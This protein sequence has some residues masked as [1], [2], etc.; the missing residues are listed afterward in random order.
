[1]KR[2]LNTIILLDSDSELTGLSIQCD[3][4]EDAIKVMADGCIVTNN[5][6]KDT[7][8]SRLPHRDAIQ[9]IPR[10][11]HQ[12]NSQFFG[13]T[14]TSVIVSDNTIDSNGSLQGIFASD[15]LFED[16]IIENNKVSTRSRHEIAIGGM[17]YGRIANNTALVTLYPLR[18]GGSHKDSF[19][20]STFTGGIEYHPIDGLETNTAYDDRRFDGKGIKDFDIDLF[21]KIASV[22]DY[23]GFDSTFRDVI[24]TYKS[25]RRKRMTGRRTSTQKLSRVVASN[26]GGRRAFNRGHAGDAGN[27]KLPEGTTVATVLQAGRK[28]FGEKGRIWAVGRYQFIPPTLK[29]ALKDGVISE[30]DIISDGAVQD[31]LFYWEITK[32]RPQVADYIR[33]TG[34]LNN[35][36]LALSKEWASLPNPYTGRSYYDKNGVDK[37]H[38]PIY[39]VRDA[40]NLAKRLF[41]N[42][43]SIYESIN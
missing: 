22:A 23:T 39:K 16:L 35:A 36:M 20:V 32:K 11:K 8:R 41:K 17:L 9:L 31:R 10:V 43:K 26:E 29:L 24:E 28:K 30:S 14:Q 3:H 18:I 21:R 1:M 15:G 4:E 7:T 34:S 6:I 25:F 13:A 2:N 12:T 42:G 27:A 38:T 40:L 37:A 19:Y 5:T 33:G